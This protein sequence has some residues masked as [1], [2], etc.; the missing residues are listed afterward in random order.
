MTGSA[1]EE[2]ESQ[3]FSAMLLTGQ[4]ISESQKEPQPKGS[5]QDIWCDGSPPG[6]NKSPGRCM[7]E[8]I[9]PG[10]C[11]LLILGVEDWSGGRRLECGIFPELLISGRVSLTGKHCL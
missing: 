7:D 5:K 1:L 4:S 3:G 10:R 2:V 6:K 8:F 9:Q 11:I